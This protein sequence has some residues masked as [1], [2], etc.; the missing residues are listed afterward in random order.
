MKKLG[1]GTMRLPL[2]DPE[3]ASS[4]DIKKT[5]ELFDRFLDEGFTYFDTAYFYHKSK[6]ES[7]IGEVLVKRHP[8]E[9]FSI[10]DKLPIDY[11]NE[12]ADVQRIYEEQKK[13]LGTEYFD[14]YF[15]HA[16]S[17]E[18]FDKAKEFGVLDYLAEKK[19]AG[20]IK[21]S[22]FSFHGKPDELAYILDNYVPELVQIQLNYYDW[23]SEGVQAKKLYDIIRSHGAEISIMEP[24]RGGALADP[25]EEVRAAIA[26][27]VPGASPAE[28]GIRFAASMPGVKVVLSGMSNMDQLT[29]NMGYMKEFEPLTQEQLQKMAALYSVLDSCTKIKCTACGYCVEGCPMNIAIPDYFALYNKS[30][31]FGKRMAYTGAYAKLTENHGKAAD[32]LSCGACESVCTQGLPI[33]SL[34]AEVSAR[35][36]K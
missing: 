22:G 20:E 14:Y 21:H 4:V 19:E 28:A 9:S 25:P 33:A 23:L 29:E 34:M 10:T 8:R 15:M 7:V 30:E 35:F 6:S 17:R 26:K 18:R 2:T 3:D 36:D 27:I 5:T 16:I 24:L 13:R 1:F 11:L 31:V 32:C 12:K